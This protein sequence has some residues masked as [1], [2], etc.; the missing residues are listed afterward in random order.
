MFDPRRWL[1]VTVLAFGLLLVMIG[2]WVLFQ[3]GVFS[4]PLF[5]GLG[6]LMVLLLVAFVRRL[7]DR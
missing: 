3:R 4:Y 7:R 1:P 2:G 6:L 5:L